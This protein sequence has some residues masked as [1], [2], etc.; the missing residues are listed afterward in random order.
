MST[1]SPSARQSVR[2]GQVV[3]SEGATAGRRR[4]VT[5]SVLCVSLLVVNLDSTI[6]NVAMPTIVRDLHASS[7]DLQWIVDVYAIVFAGL[8]LVLGSLGDRIG[9]KRV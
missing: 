2:G 4:W 1:M 5:L 7:S 3:A 9:R 8:L 6:L